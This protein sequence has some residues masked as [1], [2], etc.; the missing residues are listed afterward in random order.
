[1]TETTTLRCENCGTEVPEEEL[2]SL[3]G[4]SLCE[5]C[6]IGANH[7]IQ[8]CDPWAVRAAKVFEKTSG[9][10]AVEALTDQQRA[11]YEFIKDRGRAKP[12]EVWAKFGLTPR[13]LENIGAILR[14]C[15]LIKGQKDGSEVYWTLF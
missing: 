9:V 8:A 7:R 12:E 11:V 14:H 1:M 5:D 13:E 2:L 4:R 15:E 10:S 6:Y 3:E